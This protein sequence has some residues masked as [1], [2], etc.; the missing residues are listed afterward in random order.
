MI[1]ISRDLVE[2]FEDPD[3]LAGFVI[4]E[5]LRYEND[6]IFKDI[7]NY[8]GTFATFRLLTTGS[9]PA[10]KLRAYSKDIAHKTSNVFEF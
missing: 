8:A 4:A 5:Q 7:L 6:E 1:L 10:E 9:L 2:D 3:V